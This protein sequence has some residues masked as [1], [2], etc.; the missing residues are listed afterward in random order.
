MRARFAKDWIERKD[1][2]SPKTICLFAVLV[3]CAYPAAAGTYYV[4]TCKSGSYSS[5]SQAVY[6]A[7]AGSTIMICA[8]QYSEQVIISKD[9]TLVGLSSPT[10][11]GAY[12]ISPGLMQTTT[13]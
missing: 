1:L 9:L 8:G 6:E 3:V 10:A 2:M 13:S 7:P 12:L 11:S 5:I 4:G